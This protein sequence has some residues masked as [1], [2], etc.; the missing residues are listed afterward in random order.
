[1]NRLARSL[2]DG[3]RDLFPG[4]FA[5]V[6]AT[7]IVSIAAHLHGFESVARVLLWLNAGFFVI[8]WLLLLARLALYPRRLWF[9]LSDHLRGPGFFTLIA[10]TCVLGSQFVVL[11]GDQLLGRILWFLGIALWLFVVYTF[12]SV[13]TVKREKPPLD[14]GIHG[15]WLVAVVSTQSISVLGTLVAAG[16][17]SWSQVA[18]FFSLSMYLLG[19]MLYIWLTTL[20]LYRFLF[21]R[22]EPQQLTPPYWIGM[23]AVAIT[24]LAGATLMLNAGQWSLLQDLLPFLKGFTLFFWATSTWWIP[25]LIIL[26]IWRYLFMR[27]PLR[28]DPQ[29]WSMVFPLGMYTAC[30]FQLAKALNVPFL[31]EIPRYFIYLAFAAWLATFLG[32][33]YQLGRTLFE[34]ARPPKPEEM[35]QQK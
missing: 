10:G 11:N 27:F 9:D 8:L 18:L 26:G 1:M 7:G 25:L 34:A 16:L 4:Y 5:L 12:F 28:Y 21:F 17:G 29:F 15:V 14:A 13:V 19:G 30:T 33:I 3:I 24:T 22:V 20:I 32:L 35:P 23:G 2:R 6:M 31:V